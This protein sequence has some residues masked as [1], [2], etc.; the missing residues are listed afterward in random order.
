[1]QV[2]M[3]DFE[4]LNRTHSEHAVGAADTAVEAARFKR[5]GTVWARMGID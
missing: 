2:T 5:A 1:M 4:R 3:L